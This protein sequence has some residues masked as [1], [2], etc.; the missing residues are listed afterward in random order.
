MQIL[1][2]LLRALLVCF[3]FAFGKRGINGGLSPDFPILLLLTM[4]VTVFANGSVDAAGPIAPVKKYAGEQ[5]TFPLNY[6]FDTVAQTCAFDA[7]FF[8][9]QLNFPGTICYSSNED[10]V[11]LFLLIPAY[12]FPIDIG[13]QFITTC[14]DGYNLSGSCIPNGQKVPEKSDPGS[15]PTGTCCTGGTNP[16]NIGVGNKYQRELDYGGSS[17]SQLIFERHYNSTS[18]ME[19]VNFGLKWRSN[20]DRSVWLFS[21]AGSLS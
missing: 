8:T 20:F 7:A 11:H 6:I 9:S 19:M 17:G 16:I 13:A 21:G 5:P 3:D 15:C 18:V 12:G 10:P 4:T 14:P 1:A 2:A